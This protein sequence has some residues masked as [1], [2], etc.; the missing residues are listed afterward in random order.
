MCSQRHA[1]TKAKIFATLSSA[2][3]WPPSCLCSAAGREKSSS[4]S[5][6][7]LD[8]LL[9]IY[10]CTRMAM[11]EKGHSWVPFLSSTL[12]AQVNENFFIFMLAFESLKAQIYASKLHSTFLMWI[13]LW[14]VFCW[15]AHFS[16]TGP[17]G[18]RE[19]YQ[20]CFLLSSVE[21]FQLEF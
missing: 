2:I 8:V 16:R 6:H 7:S 17:S 9:I 10:V 11:R 20:K 3:T 13:V 1:K 4:S 15:A 5:L 21:E 14:L 19:I 18:E 12:P